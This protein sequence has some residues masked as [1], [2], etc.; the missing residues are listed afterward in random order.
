MRLHQSVGKAFESLILFSANG[1][2]EVT[3]I[4]QHPAVLFRSGRDVV[5][6]GKAWPDWVGFVQSHAIAFDA[7]STA[8]KTTFR[9]PSD[10]VHQFLALQRLARLHGVFSFYLVEWRSA[11][12]EPDYEIFRVSPCDEWPFVRRRGDGVRFG[13]VSDVWAWL[14]S[15]EASP[16]L[17]EE[18][19]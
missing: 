14:K 7:K 9:A 12:P 19:P 4:R 1:Q 3:L 11:E 17:T 10:R 16:E 13:E 2:D 5:V 18:C 8:N 6:T 15:G